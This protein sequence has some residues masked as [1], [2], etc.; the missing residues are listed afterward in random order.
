MAWQVIAQASNPDELQT[1]T[2]AIADIPNG[3]PVLIRIELQPWFPIAGIA[4]L[5]GMEWAAQRFAGS[6]N[7][8]DVSS[9][10]AHTI[11][12][13]GTAIG[14]A[15]FILV[16]IIIGALLVLGYG[17]YVYQ[18]ITVSSNIAAQAQAQQATE[19]ARENFIATYEPTLGA[20][21]TLDLLNGV[22]KPTVTQTAAN[23]SLMDD[24]TAA[25]KPVISIGAVAL[26][27]ALIYFGMQ[28]LPKPKRSAA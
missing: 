1:V 3:S 16:P 10:D 4:N 25:I 9:P 22:T 5:A 14:L 17:A 6:I 12:I 28:Y 2:P 19:A 20:Q 21:A 18:S 8:T 24:L 15:W 7:V 27:G 13:T 26:I 11:Q 23:P